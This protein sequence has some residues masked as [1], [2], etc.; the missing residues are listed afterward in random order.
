MTHSGAWR[1]QGTARHRRGRWIAASLLV[2]VAALA[3][4]RHNALGARPNDPTGAVLSGGR[5]RTYRIHVPASY[6]AGRPVA[7]VLAFHGRLGTGKGMARTT[8]L[9]TTSERHGFIVVYP[10]GVDRSWND[11]L[12]TPAEQAGVDDVAF[13]QDLIARLRARY[14][15]DPRRIYATGLSNGAMLTELLGCRLAGTLAAIAPVAGTMPTP[16][17]AGCA[18]RAALSVLLF[19]GTSDPYVPYGGGS[20]VSG[21]GSVLSAP[22]T[23]QRWSTL[24]GCA[25]PARTAALPQRVQDGTSVTV[26]A[27]GG[28]PSNVAVQLDTIVGGGHTWPGGWQYLPAFLIGHTSRQIDAS[29]AIWSFFA[30]HPL[31]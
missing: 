10:D 4:A 2:V 28:C 6:R 5:V 25:G 8:Y 15:I 27:E 13:T 24:D 11:D 21:V 23:L 12:S 1:P 22:Q 19:H 7:L 3:V 14:S 30:A 17:A 20:L 18:P 9:D 31:R 16:V 29:E 26:A